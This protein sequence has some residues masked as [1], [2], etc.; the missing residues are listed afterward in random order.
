[1][2]SFVMKPIGASVHLRRKTVRWELVRWLAVTSVPFAFAG[3]FV[4]RAFGDADAMQNR[5]KIALGVALL[6]ASGLIVIKAAL[7]RRAAAKRTAAG[8]GEAPSGVPIKVRPASLMLIGAVGGLVVGMTSV[9]S[10]SLII[11]ALMMLYPTLVGKELVGTDLVQAVPLVAAAA[12]GHILY[13]D[14]ELGLTLSLLV[15]CLPGVYIGA[16]MSAKAPDGVV[17]PLLAFVLLAS[18][19]KLVNMGTGALGWTMLIVA[20]VGLPI[21]GVIDALGWKKELWIKVGANRRSWLT[22]QMLGA[23]FAV[24]F[25]AAI[26][27]FTKTRPRL[28]A[29]AVES[30]G[31]EEDSVMVPETSAAI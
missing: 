24:G 16:R 15:G 27:Y 31:Q 26:A 20:L 25:G 13:G 12:L 9:G 3:V 30:R 22:W 29:A 8:L 1:V 6:M 4:L 11:V 7:Q 21:W 18:G 2:A 10:G 5:V 14:F 23:P 19:L 28:A 17:R